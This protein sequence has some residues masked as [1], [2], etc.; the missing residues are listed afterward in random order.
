[1]FGVDKYTHIGELF[2]DDLTGDTQN[3]IRNAFKK[4]AHTWTDSLTQI[5]KNP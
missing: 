2:F 1:M 3:A 4:E 5:I